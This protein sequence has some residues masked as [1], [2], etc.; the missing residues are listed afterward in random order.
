LSLSIYD[1]QCREDPTITRADK[2]DVLLFEEPCRKQTCHKQLGMR[3]V[4]STYCYFVVQFHLETA[5]QGCVIAILNEWRGIHWEP[6]IVCTNY[7]QSDEAF[8]VRTY[9]I[10][11]VSG[12]AEIEINR[13]VGLHE[14]GTYLQGGIRAP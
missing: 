13:H 9:V 11:R 6:D 12:R 3:L 5:H 2:F 4:A 7:D 8:D 1:A 10:I 14:K